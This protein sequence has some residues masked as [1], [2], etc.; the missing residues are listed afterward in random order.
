M[1]KEKIEYR[2]AVEAR[3][4]QV[5][6]LPGFRSNGYIVEGEPNLFCF[7]G[8]ECF[9]V[10]SDKSKPSYQCLFDS[11]TPVGECLPRP[12]VE[13]GWSKGPDGLWSYWYSRE[14]RKQ[15]QAVK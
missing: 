14:A 7:G 1:A 5:L 8:S 12:K 2:Y 10:S 11:G 4:S 13:D 9:E 3:P 6:K 15:R